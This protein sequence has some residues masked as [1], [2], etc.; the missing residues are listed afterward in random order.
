MYVSY[1]AG[2]I[3][4]VS[5][6][7]HFTGDC[8]K[9]SKYSKDNMRMLQQNN[10]TVTIVKIVELVTNSCNFDSSRSSIV[11]IHYAAN[12]DTVRRVDTNEI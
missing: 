10:S 9:V 7:Q 6:N 8:K 4:R 5:A 3:A 2:L 11:R 12:K 1:S